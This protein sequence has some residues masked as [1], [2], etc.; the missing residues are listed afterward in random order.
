MTALDS[1]HTDCATRIDALQRLKSFL[2]KAG[3]DYGRLRNYDLP[4]DGHPH[5]S[6]LSP[7]LRHRIVTEPEVLIAVLGQHSAQAAEKFIQEVCWRSYWKGWLEMRPSVWTA[8][9]RD[10]RDALAQRDRAPDLDARLTAAES[11]LTDIDA[12][13]EWAQELVTTGYLHNHA[14]MW[15]ASIWIF[16]LNLPWQLGGR[17]FFLRHLI[18]GDPAS[19]TLSWRWVAGLQTQGKHYLARSANISKYTQGRHKPEW[20]LNTQAQPLPGPAPP[21]RRSAP[22]GDHVDPQAKTAFLLTE[23]DLSPGFALDQL[24]NPPLGHA[25]LSCMAERSPRGTA[26]LVEG[27]AA[28]AIRDCTTRYANR[29]DPKGPLN[30]SVEDI[31]NWAVELGARQIVTPYAPVGPTATTLKSLKKAL[32][33]FGISVVQPMRDWDK[34]A[35]PHATHG[36]FRFKKEIPKLLESLNYRST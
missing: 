5:V 31:Q 12:F 29:L 16:T 7:Y 33:P 14:R 11:G 25:V 1:Q 17:D 19:N 35:W 24:S 36:F 32:A 3:Q 2:P 6:R 13:N 27:F 22:Q 28:T 30:G 34:A 23:E 15:F 4:Q 8:Y 9:E 21:D 18:D 26:P 10:V 20:R